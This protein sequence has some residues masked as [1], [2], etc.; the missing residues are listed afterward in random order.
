[1]RWN[2]SGILRASA[3][4]RRPATVRRAFQPIKQAFTPTLC[5]RYASTEA[6]SAREGKIHA[7][8]GAIVDSGLPG[9][10][11]EVDVAK[12]FRVAAL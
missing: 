12:T 10:I 2:C 9:L 5:A 11:P 1:M 6:S 7:V 8:I 3:N 4:L